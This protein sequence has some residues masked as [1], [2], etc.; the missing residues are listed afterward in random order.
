MRI[1]L[2]HSRYLSGPTSGEN[3]VLEDEAALLRRA[4]HDVW[5]F[6]PEPVASTFSEQVRAGISTIWSS[7]AYR[8]VRD[9]VAKESVD[10]VHA[11]NLFP[12][13]SPAVLRAGRRGGA[14]TVITLHNYR[15]MCLPA[16][17]LR[18]DRPCEDCLGHVPWRG[19]VHRCYRGSVAGS[20]A[21]AASVTLHRGIGTFDSVSRYLAVSNF[22]RDR[23]IDAGIAPGAI[24]VK[25]NF[26]PPA[27]IRRG[28]GDYFL[29]L[30][31]IA[32]EKGVD[33]LISAWRS[34]PKARL[35]IAGDGPEAPKLRSEAPPGVS[36]LGAV[37]AEEVPDLL[38]SARAVLIPSRW[39]EAAPRVITEAYAAGVPVIASDVGALPEAV[40]SGKTG[41]LATVDDPAA[42]AEVVGRLL[43]DAESE[44]MGNEALRAWRDRFTPERGLA[45]LESEYRMAMGDRLDL[46][47]SR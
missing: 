33:T 12:A 18:G 23:H 21:V 19:V 47:G 24:G 37:A 16:N 36:F 45:A 42:W 6:T 4:G 5:R 34:S 2:V 14:A 30:G 38:A 15:L 13:L 26:T 8:V 29:F 17:L 39:Y 32:H 35:L 10:I 22:V 46:A 7:H 25:P 9:F 28:A 3:R 1:L 11:H 27:R 40:E 31:R 20:A 41:Y 43:D 44:R